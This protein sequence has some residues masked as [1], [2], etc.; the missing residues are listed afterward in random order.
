MGKNN[1]KGNRNAQDN[2]KKN[3]S[4]KKRAKRQAVSGFSTLNQVAGVPKRRE[5]HSDLPIDKVKKLEE[6]SGIICALCGKP[7]ETIADSFTYNDGYVHFDCALDKIKE[8]EQLKDN[9]TISYI[10]SGS[11][12]VCEKGDD[13]KYTIIK[14]IAFE[15][16]ES[17]GKMQEYIEGLKR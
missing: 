16:S 17:L 4:G 2:K 3:S 11:F 9:Q 10:G 13:G 5:Y 6:P 1:N 12:G 15:S 7:I 8:S 14:K